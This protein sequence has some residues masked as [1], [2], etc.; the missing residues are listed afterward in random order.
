MAPDPCSLTPASPIYHPHT[1]QEAELLDEV[2]SLVQR[3]DDLE[4]TASGAGG[5]GGYGPASPRALP[6][7][8]TASASGDLSAPTHPRS[9]LHP[10][11]SVPVRGATADVAATML[12]SP[13]L[14]RR[15]LAA[16]EA[17][18]AD[19][20]PSLHLRARALMRCRAP[21][22]RAEVAHLTVEAE[23]LFVDV[24]ALA[25]FATVNRQGFRKA[26]KKHDKVVGGVPGWTPPPA[27][28]AFMPAIDK[29]FDERA[30]LDDLADAADAVVTAYALVAAG[31][32]RAAASAELRAKL[33]DTVALERGTVWQD[34][35]ARER[36]TATARV[37]RGAERAPPVGRAARARA[38][39]RARRP[40]CQSWLPWPSSS[41][42]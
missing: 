10:S 35:V 39:G 41:V 13:L 32:S 7:S 1:P 23:E 4:A 26:L 28:P 9:P 15:S 19:D 8:P 30:R 3:A 34:M 36:R 14:A 38:R 6:L 42:S 21:D 37:T 18:A 16:A 12:R 2:R 25:E 22:V 5:A 31:G 20:D 27:T 11:R 33:R 29:G 24:E 17:A 40:P